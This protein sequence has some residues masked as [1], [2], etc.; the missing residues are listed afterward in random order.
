MFGLAKFMMPIESST[1]IRYSLIFITSFLPIAEVRGGIP[2]AFYY[3]YNDSSR[4]VW[5]IAV[6]VVANLL[7]APFVLYILKYIDLFIKRSRIVPKP[8]RKIYLWILNH[9]E[10]RGR[11]LRKYDIPTLVTFVAIP[12]PVTGAWTGSLI[13]F[14]IGMDRKRALIAI[15]VGVVIASL[16]VLSICLLGLE[17]LK[18]IFLIS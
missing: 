16:I 3:F 12:F 8:I 9:S 10:N 1:L 5:G 7:I 2:L 18:R 11:K 13:A 14:L 15:E 6:A 4:L 17:V